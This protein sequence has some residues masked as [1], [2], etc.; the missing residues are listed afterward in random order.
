V[1]GIQQVGSRSIVE[2]RK[3]RRRLAPLGQ[4]R[5]LDNCC[6]CSDW[7]GSTIQQHKITR[8]QTA[9]GSTDNC[10]SLL[11]L[12]D[13]ITD[14]HSSSNT[15]ATAVEQQLQLLQMADALTHRI[16]LIHW[17]TV[18][19]NGDGRTILGTRRISLHGL[20]T[21]R[22]P[23]QDSRCRDALV[24]RT[25]CIGLAGVTRQYGFRDLDTPVA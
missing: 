11:C 9:K 6:Y 5:G 22:C 25:P 23:V 8:Q 7:E 10:R 1:A 13:N 4:V 20:S 15:V 17:I 21:T 2:G 19:R 24:R 16:V 14:E 3:R 18:F 12:N